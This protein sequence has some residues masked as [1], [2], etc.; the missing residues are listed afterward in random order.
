M[1]S[2][3]TATRIAEKSHRNLLVIRIE[4]FFDLD[5]DTASEIEEGIRETLDTA[6]GRAGA[7]VV[8]T[9]LTTETDEFLNKAISDFL[10]QAP[11]RIEFD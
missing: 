7:R 8:S 1:A 5:T 11:T 4:Q 3:V 6:R 2:K 9:Y 10:I